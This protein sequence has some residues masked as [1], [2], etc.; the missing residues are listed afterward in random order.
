[1]IANVSDLPL[2]LKLYVGVQTDSRNGTYELMD[3]LFNGRACYMQIKNTLEK[4]N[5]I[6][7]IYPMAR[8]Q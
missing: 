6:Q 8:K 1:M 4:L 3:D 5:L 2:Y 7:K